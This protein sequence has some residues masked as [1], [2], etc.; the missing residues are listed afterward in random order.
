[1]YEISI[2]INSPPILSKLIYLKTKITKDNTIDIQNIVNVKKLHLSDQ[3]DS[4]YQQK[5][6]LVP[7]YIPENNDDCT[8]QFESRFESGNLLCAFKTEETPKQINYQ[9]LLQ[10]DT[11]TTGY[12]QWFFFRVTNVKKKKKVNINIINM[13]RK[14]SMYSHGLKIMCYSQKKSEIENIGWHRGGT[15]VMYYPNNLYFYSNDRKRNLFSLSFDYE[16]AYDDD[17]VFFANCI[18]FFYSDLMKDLN[19]YELNETK[20]PFF[21]RKTLC[22]T[23]GGNNL[24]MFSINSLSLTNQNLHYY[25]M[26]DTRKGIIL[27]ARQHP[28]ET[29]SSYVMKGAYEFL[30][31]N[32]DE[33]KKLRELYMIR[34]VPMMNPDGVL[35]G[36]SR[37]S[38]AGCDLN[39]RWETPNEVIHPEIFHTKQMILKMATQREIAFICDFHGHIG[40]FNSFF[41]C[42]HKTNKRACSLFPFICSKLSK[43]ISY[44]QSNFQMPKYKRGTGRINL[45]NELDL[46]NIVTLETSFFGTNRTGELNRLYYTKELLKEIGRDICLGMLS[47]YYKYEK[48]QIE[49]SLLENKKLDIDMKEFEEEITKEENEENEEDENANVEGIVEENSESEPSIDNFEK[50]K[51]MNLLPTKSKKKKNKS[52]NSLSKRL[53]KINSTKKGNKNDLSMNQTKNEIKLYNPLKTPAKPPETKPLIKSKSMSKIQ[54]NCKDTK[55]VDKDAPSPPVPKEKDEPPSNKRDAETQTEEIFFKMHWSHFAGD[56]PILQGKY[57]NRRLGS[58][59]DQFGGFSNRQKSI[60][61]PNNVFN[62]YYNNIRAFNNKRGYPSVSKPGSLGKGGNNKFYNNN[63]MIVQPNHYIKKGFGY[64]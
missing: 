58:S 62:N 29:V 20:Y 44:N 49:K 39:R 16:F 18:P 46:N 21:H 9:L 27:I 28:G 33:A 42:N 47:Y 25:N 64:I 6:D 13:L 36:N 61:P 43:I 17:T 55:T 4:M 63:R 59:R 41:Y 12:I 3:N 48:K 40:A 23:L 8:L 57:Q 24:D 22:T 51:I 50:D 19:Y 5:D 38:F 10:N 26:N 52:K 54:I 45:F 53:Y 37:T 60:G 31:G 14:T 15:N 1:M 30:V 34:I 35:V 2:Y 11:N 32:S 56:Y 7:Y